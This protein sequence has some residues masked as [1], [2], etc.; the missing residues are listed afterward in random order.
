MA[1]DIVRRIE[2]LALIRIRDDGDRSVVLV[3]DDAAARV[4][5]RELT[6]L[7]IERVA[8]AV[9]RGL[10]EH[11]DLTIILEPP[12]LAVVRDVAPD[13]I[14]PLSVPCGT[15][16]PHAARPQP[17]NRR[18]AD[19]QGVE[20][21]IDRDD[22]GIGIGDRLGKIARRIRDRRSADRGALALVRR[23]LCV[24]EPRRK[25]RHP[26]AAP[27]FVSTSRRET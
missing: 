3:S 2:P 16:A 17:L 15:F 22:V 9:A 8:V 4:L 5:A 1:R 6:A 11:G 26:A 12:Q 13:Q 7:M 18:V 27:I 14:L 21:G 19:T 20:R 25:R 10:T 24:T 23:R